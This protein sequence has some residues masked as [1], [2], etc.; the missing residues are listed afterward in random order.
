MRLRDFINRLEQLS[1]VSGDFVEVAVNNGDGTFTVAA[2]EVQQVAKEFE[3]ENEEKS[4][5]VNRK[6]KNPIQIISIF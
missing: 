4:W 2:A 6:K 5:K 1:L 3:N